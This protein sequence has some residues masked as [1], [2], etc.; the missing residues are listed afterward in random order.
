MALDF[1]SSPQRIGE[2][3]YYAV[4]FSNYM[5]GNT[6]VSYSV[7]AK[8]IDTGESVQVL[9]PSLVDS[10]IVSMLVPINGVTAV[11]VD[12]TTD[13]GE[14]LKATIFIPVA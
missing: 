12:A 14:K 5:D 7:S 9:N 6:V 13:V 10:K 1:T 11:Y 8:L 4:D 3:I 2:T